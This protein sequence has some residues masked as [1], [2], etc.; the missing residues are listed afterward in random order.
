MLTL[1]N[2][3]IDPSEKQS[4][5]QCLICYIAPKSKSNDNHNSEHTSYIFMDIHFNMN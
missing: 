1:S 3:V 4:H 2:E 5:L